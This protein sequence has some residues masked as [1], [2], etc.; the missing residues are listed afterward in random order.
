M[1]FEVCEEDMA[2]VCLTVATDDERLLQVPVGG[3]AVIEDVMA[4]LEVET[5]VEVIRQR[6][7]FEGKE[8]QRSAT[9]A[10]SGLKDGDV[11]MM[12]SA[13]PPG[14][15]QQQQQQG[16]GQGQGQQRQMLKEAVKID[17]QT[18]AA[19][20]PTAFMDAFKSSPSDLAGIQQMDPEFA[21]IIRS[22][23][24]N[25]L[26]AH[27]KNVHI[28]RNQAQEQARREMELHSADPFD[29][30]AQMEIEKRIMQNQVDEN[31]QTALEQT[32]E[33]FTTVSMLYIDVEVNG[34]PL[35]GF[36]DSGA[37]RTIMSDSCAKTCNLTRLMDVRY[38]GTA[39]GIGTSTILGR[40]HSAPLQIG[41]HFFPC[42]FDI[43]ENQSVDLLLGLDMLKRFQ[44]CIDLE[45]NELRLGSGTGV[46]KVNFLS[47]SESHSIQYA[48]QKPQ[49]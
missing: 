15:Q 49:T 5:G 39:H 45:K 26:Q 27:L 17:P 44:C 36:V 4:V 41:G 14:Q 24:V 30:N 43:M 28:R 32:P 11:V 42:T 29:I 38:K 21:N 22:G 2:H 13:A 3:D 19:I 10:Q 48:A 37:Q 31:L 18:G 16:Q 25:A 34:F 6:L 7:V 33:S 47:E 40:V 9:V 8:L 1:V 46:I 23:D 20:N 35:K 12:I